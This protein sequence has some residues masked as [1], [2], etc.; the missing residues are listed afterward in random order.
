MYKFYIYILKTTKLRK[1]Q[2]IYDE[3]KKNPSDLFQLYANSYISH[4]F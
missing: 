3:N 4:V 1:Q 2:K